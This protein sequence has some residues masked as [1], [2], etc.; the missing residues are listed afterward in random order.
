VQ[1]SGQKS[2]DLPGLRNYFGN[3]GHPQ[4]GARGEVADFAG[5]DMQQGGDQI[6]HLQE[7]PGSPKDRSN[8]KK[9]P[10]L[11]VGGD[12]KGYV[13]GIWYKAATM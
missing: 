5:G 1:Q 13:L 6:L 7:L 8:P 3:A 9:V 2:Q 4:D 10:Q 12:E 11:Q